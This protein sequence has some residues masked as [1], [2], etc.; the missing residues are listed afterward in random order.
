MLL[1]TGITG[2]SGKYFLQELI[3]NKY[4]GPI[5]CIVRSNSDTS[6]IDNSRLN[7]EKIVGDLENQEFLNEVMNGVSTVVHIASIFYSVNVIRAAIK[8]N[9]KKAILVHTTGIYSKYKSASEE[10]KDIEN[11]IDRIIKDNN[12]T[13]GLIYLRPTMIYGYINDSNMIVFIK[14]VDRLRLFP[15]IDQGRNLLQPVNGRDLGKAYYQVLRKSNIISGDYI[16]SGERPISMK[17]LFTLISQ[18]LGKKTKFISFP[19][20]LGVFM[21]R[22]IKVCTLGKVDYIEKVQRMGE[23]RSFSHNSATEDFDYQPMLLSEGLKIEI[24]EY[25]KKVQ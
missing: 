21:A 10:Y 3:K 7:I 25:L 11:S 12:S 13:I 1:V 6:M 22:F 2:H 9:V 23:D 24:E 8:N 4:D 20:A 19:L 14:M 17:E 5:R 15:I 16:L 18:I